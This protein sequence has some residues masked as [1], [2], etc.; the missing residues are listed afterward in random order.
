MRF[1]CAVGDRITLKGRY[2]LQESDKMLVCIS[3]SKNSINRYHI[4]VLSEHELV[5][6]S[7]SGYN[8]LILHFK[9]Y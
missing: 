8:G 7:I 6:K 4:S 2:E 9:P 5:L 3:E 1:E